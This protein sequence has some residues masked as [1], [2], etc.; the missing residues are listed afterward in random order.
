MLSPILLF[1]YNRFEHLENTVNSLKANSLARDSELHIFSDGPK[2]ENDMGV[3]TVRQYIKDI[4]GFKKIKIYENEFNAGLADSIIS[5]VSKIIESS[6]KVIVVEDDLV[7][8]KNF[9][10]YMNRALDFYEFDDKTMSISAYNYPTDLFKV[11]KHYNKDVFYSLRNS[12]WG[13]GTWKNCWNIVDWE[14]KDYYSFIKDSNAIK[15][16]N[17]GGEDLTR[18]IK[19][20]NNN[21]I[22]S[23]AIRF[24]YAHY[25]NNMYSVTPIET[26]VDNTGHDG[27]GTHT[28]KNKSFS[29]NKM[30]SEKEIVFED[31][32]YDSIVQ[33]RHR[34]V[35]KKNIIYKVLRYFYN[36][37]LKKLNI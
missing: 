13:W 25:K 24:C 27:S 17:L 9:L 14:L 31:L 12:S 18:M 4:N 22:S 36:K 2:D 5:G 34:L 15:K 20:Q 35:F 30:F 6:N 10:S 23:W 32:E 33:E 16:F 3:E 8:S 28:R 26:L 19:M 21:E 37:T 7:V 29:S 1:V 11:P